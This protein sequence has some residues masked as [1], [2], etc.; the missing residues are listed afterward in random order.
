MVMMVL[1]NVLVVYVLFKDI[2]F[3]IDIFGLMQG[4]LIIQVKFSLFFVIK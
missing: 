2:I 3:V 1:L 4:N